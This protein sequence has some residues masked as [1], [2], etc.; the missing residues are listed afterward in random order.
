MPATVEAAEITDAYRRRIAQLRDATART[1]VVRFQAVDLDRPRE[2]TTWA[3][4]GA[5]LIEAAQER[6][7]TLS[8]GYLDSYLEASGA[9]ASP[10]AFD[11]ERHVG[12]LRGTPLAEALRAVPAAVYWRLS[13]RAGRVAALAYGVDTTI[14]VSR[15][16]VSEASRAALRDQMIAQPAVVG[17]RRVTSGKPCGACLALAG[18]RMTD[19][20]VFETHDRCSCSAEPIVRGVR[21]RAT[22]P[23][24]QQMFEQ[25]TG[26]QRAELFEG[27]GGAAKA[28]LVDERGLDALI[29]RLNG[30]L[31]ET[32]LAAL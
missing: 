15:A 19:S 17:W 27:T 10:V 30:Q 6:A 23:T 9:E 18:Q 14:R 32:P 28:R 21:E 22:R 24:G 2:F 26:A 3:T 8:L 12:A 25:M 16:A 7:A 5:L 11:P 29:S 13:R 4:D 31:V 20:D 1:L